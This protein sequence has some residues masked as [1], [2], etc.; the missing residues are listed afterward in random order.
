M[1]AILL[2]VFD[3]VINSIGGEWK[4]LKLTK[5]FEHD[6][7]AMIAAID[8]NTKLVYITNPNNPTATITNR[9]K[10]YKFC[11]LASKKVPI[12]VD[13]A[14]L[15]ISEGGLQNSMVDLISKGRDVIVTRTFSK[16]H[17]M[18]GMRLGYMIASKERIAQIAAI[19]RGGMG[20]SGPT[21]NAAMASLDDSGFFL[22]AKKN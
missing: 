9:D 18:A 1:S 6:L 11:D 19:T 7:D 16:I 2:Y 14:Y 8:S 12:F 5:N 17:G 10:L 22:I 13:E 4:S 3:R 20:I 21:L 15:E